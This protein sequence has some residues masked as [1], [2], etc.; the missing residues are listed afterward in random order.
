MR[1][2]IKVKVKSGR[3]GIVEENGNYIAYLKS[4]PEKGKAN[5]EL[6]K[7]AKK[8][9]GKEVK[10]KSGLTSKRKIIQIS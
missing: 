5:Q 3:S 2:E 1:I 7:I 4:E 9:F 10:I 6:V 8:Y